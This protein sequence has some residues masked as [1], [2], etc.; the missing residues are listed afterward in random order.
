MTRYIL[1]L[2]LLGPSSVLAAPIT[3]INPGFEDIS[4][5]NPFN[6]FTFG[7]LNGWGLYD[8]SGITAGGAGGTYFIGTLRPTPPDFFLPGSYHGER[9][10]I[11]FNFFGSGDQGEYGLQQTLTETLQPNTTYTLDVGI[12]NI[13]SG[14]AENGTFF[15]ID[16]FPGYRVDLLAGGVVLASDNNSL[17]GVIGEGQFADS[18]TTFSTGNSHAQ[19]G[20]Q[21]QIRLV[22]LNL[23]DAAF[24]DA[25]LEVDFDNVRLDATISA[26]PEPSA[27]LPI[28]VAVMNLMRIRRR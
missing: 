20:Q 28:L 25:D 23:V 7:P 18:T 19:L 26:V 24:P 2:S 3:V 14:T 12:G 15:N 1:L 11:A 27:A 6:E 10:G 5:E 21:L 9:V 22:N 13:S 16:G 4:G 8:P 17:A